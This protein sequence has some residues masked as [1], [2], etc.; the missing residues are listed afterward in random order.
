[1]LSKFSQILLLLLITFSVSAAPDS[2]QVDRS[3]VDILENT[4]HDGFKV[5]DGYKSTVCNN[6]FAMTAINLLMANIY[7]NDAVVK[8]IYENLNLPVPNVAAEN[9]ML[10]G[11]VELLAVTTS[12]LFFKLFLPIFLGAMLVMSL[13]L[14]N[15][16]K[17]KELTRQK[18]SWY[19]AA[20]LGSI[21][22]LVYPV[23]S[24]M[25]GQ[26]IVVAVIGMALKIAVFILSSLLAVFNFEVMSSG[27]S[28]LNELRNEADYFAD[29]M[30]KSAGAQ[31]QVALRLNKVQSP[32]L[33]AV[34]NMGVDDVMKYNEE[35]GN[36]NWSFDLTSPKLI[37][38]EQSKPVTPRLYLTNMLSRSS[39]ALEVKSPFQKRSR[40]HGAD[41]REVSPT[42]A[43]STKVGVGQ[44]AID[45]ANILSYESL[46]RA[47]GGIGVFGESP[48]D[49][50]FYE[51]MI[52]S[53]EFEDEIFA[54]NV[55]G[56]NQ[57]TNLT[58][59]E[60]EFNKV[61]AAGVRREFTYELFSK[62]LTPDD[63]KKNA[64]ILINRALNAYPLVQGSDQAELAQ[65]RLRYINLT[66]L[67]LLGYF[68][69]YEDQNHVAKNT[70]TNVWL[71]NPLNSDAFESKSKSGRPLFSM[72]E[73][74]HKAQLAY[75]KIQCLDAAFNQK[76]SP[77]IQSQVSLL[78]DLNE[79]KMDVGNNS[80]N[81]TSQCFYYDKTGAIQMLLP[82]LLI[83]EISSALDVGKHTPDQ[84]SEGLYLGRQVFLDEVSTKLLPEVDKH[85]GRIVNYAYNTSVLVNLAS[86]QIVK[87]NDYASFDV[88]KEMRVKGVSSVVGYFAKSGQVVNKLAGEV[89][90]NSISPEI[91]VSVDRSSWVADFGEDWV[92]DN[93]EYVDKIVSQTI[94]FGGNFDT[95]SSGRYTSDYIGAGETDSGFQWYWTMD[96]V[97]KE[98][99]N[100]M[101]VSPDILIEGFGMGGEGDSVSDAYK[102]CADGSCF[103]FS[104]HPIITLVQYGT[105]LIFTGV[106]LTL[107]DG[108]VDALYTFT[109]DVS[110]FVTQFTNGAV[111]GDKTGVILGGLAKVAG[112]TFKVVMAALKAVMAIVAPLGTLY[113][114]MGIMLALVLPIIPMVGHL[115]A[116]VMWFLESLLVF[117]LYPLFLM[118]VMVKVDGRR[119]LGIGKFL[120]IHLS[121]LF[122]PALLLVS[123]IMFYAL[124]YVGIYMINSIVGVLL[125][126][127]SEN[128]ILTSVTGAFIAIL[129]LLVTV[130][131]Y[132]KL[133]YKINETTL[134]IPDRVFRYIGVQGFD[135]GGVGELESFVGGAALA[136]GV[137]GAAAK[138][139]EMAQKSQKK[140][141]EAS[142]KKEMSGNFKKELD[143]RLG[144]Q[145]KD[146]GDALSNA[147]VNVDLD[148]IL[149]DHGGD[150]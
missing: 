12:S 145:R 29:S 122:K 7:D 64:D 9:R 91:T 78:K 112:G 22:I 70:D 125:P 51:P 21:A 131:L 35:M 39:I 41:L 121:I 81:H 58:K 111:G 3:C 23:D 48:S 49:V 19:A 134:Q 128:S 90:N 15:G 17:I 100:M 53:Q 113:L 31:R 141:L 130:Y 44:S 149:Q 135:V 27:N 150:K 59:N 132:Y 71:F 6:D 101:L 117:V 124:S 83:S 115:I 42:L 13:K 54:S 139:P 92:E 61:L 97:M 98:V 105:E 32:T 77:N 65:K 79:G 43:Y 82:D 148:K 146:I 88:V 118:L 108:V 74:A 16:A 2:S 106:M 68:D 37:T 4:V 107:L 73:D 8:D 1:M 45:R 50:E 11:L 40:F 80:T 89:R 24:Y 142:L 126:D 119:L 75:S 94:D 62:A 133:I 60:A 5:A 26:I 33:K 143:G 18:Q 93:P 96:Q 56:V 102:K 147:G 25:F 87:Q 140:Q 47:L 46:D 86:A 95:I 28:G 36:D 120:G 14:A 114:L 76:T 66:G 127:T 129:S 67:L 110:D 85:R 136:R 72:L 63:L 84:I 34:V 38:G 138:L 55:F 69:L 52:V 103:S 20:G 144:A 123:F 30:V 137:G 116:W 104:N 10:A 109:D 57:A 99:V